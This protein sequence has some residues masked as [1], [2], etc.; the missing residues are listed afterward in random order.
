MEKKLEINNIE[1]IIFENERNPNEIKFKQVINY[2]KNEEG[3]TIKTTKTYK[4]SKKKIKI[5]NNIEQRK[6]WAKFGDAKIGE[7]GI[8]I[9]G[10]PVLL[11]TT[12]KKK[13]LREKEAINSVLKEN[14][15]RELWKPKKS[16]NIISNN[17]NIY[18]PHGLRNSQ[19]NSD[20]QD[21]CTIRISNLS[22]NIY[23]DDLRKLCGFFGQLKRVCIVKDKHTNI[24][25]GFA[26]V[27]YILKEDAIKAIKGLCGHGYDNLILYVEMATSPRD[28][29][30]RYDFKKNT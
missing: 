1:T 15:V 14:N 3:K 9:L 22:E 2:S 8:T 18:I 21:D 4:I 25:R 6:K 28:A 13:E 29:T 24:P 20:R 30:A 23:D 7:Q 16:E 26:F 12:S 27:T 5:N 10:D 19:N 11:E 17:N